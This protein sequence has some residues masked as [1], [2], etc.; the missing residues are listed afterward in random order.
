MSQTG[1]AL[2]STEFNARLYLT[3]LELWPKLKS[4]LNQLSHPSVL[5]FISEAKVL[6]SGIAGIKRSV[7]RLT[8]YRQMLSQKF[9]TIHIPTSK[10]PNYNISVWCISTQKQSTECPNL[11]ITCLH[12]IFF[13]CLIIFPL[14]ICRYSL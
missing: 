12:P 13:Y 10:L 1:P 9:L 8:I 7:S 3:T 5:T 2:V 4:S 14:S 6:I 11:Q